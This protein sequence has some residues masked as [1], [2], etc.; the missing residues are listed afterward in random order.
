MAHEKMNLE[1][2]NLREGEEETARKKAS[3]LPREAR[4]AKKE[5]RKM[6]DK[7]PEFFIPPAPVK[8]GFDRPEVGLAEAWGH[9]GRPSR[10]KKELP[11]GW[12]PARELTPREEERLQEMHL[13]VKANA[14]E[15]ADWA[16]YFELWV[17]KPD[18][19]TGNGRSGSILAAADRLGERLKA[20]G[21]T[22]NYVPGSSG[23]RPL[24]VDQGPRQDSLRKL[25]PR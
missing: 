1:K 4:Q 6:G 5:G 25:P 12:R 17:K 2:M 10:L 21:A 7:I 24:R 3:G 16:A 20:A 11:E 9:I 13:W 14:V 22:Y 8:P 15:K 23:P 18:R 19:G